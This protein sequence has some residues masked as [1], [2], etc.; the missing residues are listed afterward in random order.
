M[1]IDNLKNSHQYECLHP[2]FKRAFAFMEDFLEND[3][4][5]GRY[6]I[7]GDDLFALVQTY[8]TFPVTECKW[9]SH[10]RYIDIQFVVSGKEIIGVA[11]VKDLNPTAP[12]SFENDITFFHDKK[13][14][15]I[16]M[17]AGMYI[18]LYPWE[19]HMPRCIYEEETLTKKIV[20][21]IKI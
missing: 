10:H 1:I 2:L 4:P 5:A 16:Q 3:K 11:P 8:H 13:G 15:D 17:T 19:A 12:Y 20:M 14:Y 9:E 21:K 7:E 18:I 6:E